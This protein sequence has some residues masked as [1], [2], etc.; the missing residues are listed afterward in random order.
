MK[1][2]NIR[3]EDAGVRLDHYLIGSIKDVSRSHLTQLIKSSHITVNHQQVKAGY[4][5][6]AGDII[7]I[8]DVTPQSLALEPVDLKLNIV[9][10]DEDLLVIDK[11]SGLVVH[12][13]SS[14]KAPTLVHGLLHH[15]DKLSTINGVI[16]PGIVHRIDKD[17]SGLL[18]VAKTDQAHQI[19]SEDLK[20][21]EV[22][23]TYLALVYGGFKE[24]VG[25]V[26]APIRRSDKNRL[27]MAVDPLGKHAI[28]HF[29]V[30]K[31]FV[32]YTLLECRLETG[33]THQIRVHMAYIGHPIV[34][35]ALY[36]PKPVIGNDGQLLHASELSFV[37]PIKKE[38]MTFKSEIPSFF[39]RFIDE[40]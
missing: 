12:P 17:T 32:K 13:A 19:L 24:S 40:L 14:Y 16:R 15:Q 26:D 3:H 18:V 21:H 22:K 39:K 33:R 29:K 36:G 5:L 20:E 28:T 27:K 23:R 30:L 31:S 8:N 35:D 9:Y 37:H 11:P 1:I 6:K 7:E 25:M 34:G 4:I 10:E 2:L 38:I